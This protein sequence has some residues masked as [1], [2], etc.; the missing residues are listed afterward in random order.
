MSFPEGHSVNDGIPSDLCSLKYST[1]ADAVELIRC[2]GKDALL[3]KLDLK[4]A[5]RVVPVHPE[6]HHRLGMIWNGQVYVNI[7]LPFS[8]CSAPKIFSA[9]ADGIA[10]VMHCKVLQS[11]IHYLDDFLL[12]GSPGNLTSCQSDLWSALETSTSLGFPV[13]PEKVE[14]PSTTIV[15]LGI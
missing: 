8:L 1:V 12:V 4:S 11:L 3:S 10:W 2:Q 7:C 15:F 13:A 9:V 6:D 5:Y 14:G